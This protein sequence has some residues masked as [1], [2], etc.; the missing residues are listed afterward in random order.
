MHPA[1]LITESIALTGSFACVG[2]DPRP[3]LLPPALI[4][5][6]AGRHGDTAQAVASAFVE[7]NKGIIEAV[8]GRCAVVKPQAACYEAYGSPGWDALAATVEAAHSAGIPVIVDAK[9]GDIGS[10]ADH[11]AQALFGGAPTLGGA[12]VAGLGAD[13]VTVNAYMGTEAIL[14]FLADDPGGL[15]RATVAVTERGS[16]PVAAAVASPA[17]TSG[18]VFVLVRTSNPSG[19][20]VQ[21]LRSGGVGDDLSTVADEVARLVERMGDGRHGTCGFSDVGAVVGATHPEEARRLRRLMPR[22]LFL[23]PGYGAQ[24]GT[25]VD[26]VAGACSDGSGVLVSASRSIAGAWQH[27]ADDWRA[28]AGD[29]LDRMN[30]ELVAALDS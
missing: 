9:R 30:L 1:D 20:E 5:R 2:L 18:G 10:T 14:P 4:A 28:A 13:W 3:S 6:H 23:V 17:A 27:G 16:M 11:Y 8:G 22:A 29:E 25:A 7:F 15:D 12:P 24:G 26:A 19:G 21:A